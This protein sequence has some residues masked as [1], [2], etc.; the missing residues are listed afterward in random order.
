VAVAFQKRLL[1]IEEYHQMVE[2]GILSEDERLELIHGELIEMTSIGNR[3]A[4]CV[5]WLNRC[6]NARLASRSVVD[7][8]DPVPL[9]D[10]QS[11]PQP[12]VVLLRYQEDC[13]RAQA[14]RPED[15]LLIVEAADTS[16]AYDRDVKIPLYA[17]SG[18][19]E[20]WLVDLTSDSIFS[21]RRP[22]AGG[23]LEVRR[24]RRGDT[25]SPEAFPEEGFSVDEILG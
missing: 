24:F 25:I 21:Y 16:L 22:S 19:S 4:G 10:Q 6:F 23:Y 3:H 20:A 11:E 5:R 9:G 15:V 8:Q 7:V 2:A 12:D 1:T 17:K 14:P 18:I 13:Y